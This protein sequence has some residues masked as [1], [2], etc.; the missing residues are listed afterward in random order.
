[1][2]SNKLSR[3]PPQIILWGGTGQAKVI[4]PIIEHYGSRVVAVFDDTKELESPFSDVPIYQGYDAFRKWV[5]TRDPSKIGFCV[6]IGNPHGGVRIKFHDLLLG[7]GLRPV[8]AIHPLAFVAANAT[9]GDGAQIL[10]GAVVAAEVRMGRQCII[11]THASV[12][13]ECNLG[14]GVEVG[15]GATLCGVVQVE[16]HAWIGAGATILPRLRI[17]KRAIVGAGA[18]VT[19]DVLPGRTV[20]GVPARLHKRGRKA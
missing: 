16:A 20:T 7:D 4:R 17:G 8:H 9:L 5:R 10:A 6:T 2:K 12:D 1:M 19:K 3:L 13:H 14:D 18:V 11:N 15:P